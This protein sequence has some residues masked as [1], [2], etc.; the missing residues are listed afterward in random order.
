MTS[1]GPWAALD[2]STR[3]FWT[4]VGRRV[5]LGG[6]ESWLD[7]PT[8]DAVA[9]GSA[10]LGRAARAIGGH[11]AAKAVDAGL[12]ADLS[13]LDGPAFSAAGLRPEVREFYEHTSRWRLEAWSQW[14]PV[15]AP[16]GLLVA[17]F[18][19][20][21]VQQLALPVRPLDLSRGMDSEVVPVLDADGRQRWAGWIR[22]MRST[23]D[24]VFSGAYGASR[25]PGEEGP[26][27]QVG[28]PLEEGNVQVFL[29]PRVLPGGGLEL[30]SPTGRFGAAGAYVLVRPGETSSGHAAR[31]PVHERFV[32]VVDPEGVLRTD[33]ELRIGAWTAVRLHYR[34][35]RSPATRETGPDA[36]G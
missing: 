22:T 19:G 20:R 36:P 16:G 27:V 2:R 8:G 31:V 11:V 33:H 10:W 17:H 12:L 23:G 14:S 6:P 30:L 1:R 7:A 15:F 24:V 28:F 25:L 21:R 29:K 26:C 9:G 13:V 34:M 32:V 5:D 4:V 18:F 3:R 35:D